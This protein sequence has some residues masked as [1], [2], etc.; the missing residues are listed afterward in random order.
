MRCLSKRE[1][2]LA[3]YAETPIERRSGLTAL[4]LAAQALEQ[5]LA[6]YDLDKSQIDG[7]ALTLAQSECGDPFWSNLVVETLGLTPE[8]LQVTD[9]GGAS[10]VASVARASAAI[11]AG[12]CDVVVCMAADAPTGR[13]QMRP[14]G[15]REEFME[16]VGY[17]GPPVV[18][19]LLGSAYAARHGWPEHAMAHLAVAQRNGALLNPNACSTLKQP[20]TVDDYLRSKW[21]A[22]PLRMLDCVMRCDGASAVLVCSR[23]KARA[24]GLHKAVTPTAYREITNFDPAAREPDITT[25]GFTLAGPRALADAGL[26]ASDVQMLQPYDDFLFAVLLQLEQMGFCAAG[27]GGAYLL[28]RNLGHAGDLP[29]NTGGGQISAGQPG[30]A[31]GG[32]N[33]VEAVRQ[34]MG[35]AGERQ[36]AQPRNAVV[37]GIGAMQ[38][39]KSWGTSAVLVLEV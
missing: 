34:L 33:L 14:A 11:E 4:E 31:S 22:K 35:E 24:L 3:G 39:A 6:K 20:L 7:V 38:Y 23:E 9:L 26:Q 16:T 17:G 15:Y 8:W 28:E 36:V 18:F 12:C 13:M 29:L 25:S 32:V 27:Q 30:L 37:T 10:M 2:V 19:G 5:L 21:V 1:I